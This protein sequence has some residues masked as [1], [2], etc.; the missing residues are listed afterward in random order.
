MDEIQTMGS[1]GGRMCFIKSQDIRNMRKNLIN[2]RNRNIL[3]DIRSWVRNVQ[4]IKNNDSCPIIYF[5]DRNVSD[6]KKILSNKDLMLIIM[7]KFQE[8]LLKDLG[9]K[10]LCLDATHCQENYEYQLLTIYTSDGNN[11]CPVVYCLTNIV[12]FTSVHY[13][14]K[15]VNEK[16]V[17][18]RCR[19][20]LSDDNLPFYDAW[21]DIISKPEHHFIHSW[22]IEKNWRE[23]ISKMKCTDNVKMMFYK[24][25]K[26]MMNE[27][28]EKTFEKMLNNFLSNFQYDTRFADFLSYFQKKYIKG[29]IQ[30]ANCYRKQSGVHLESSIELE[31]LHKRLYEEFHQSVNSQ[32]IKDCLN[33]LLVIS[34][35]C[36]VMSKKIMDIFHEEYDLR[37]R[38]IRDSHRRAVCIKRTEIS[39]ITP[40]L[41][42]V[43][44]DNLKNEIYQIHYLD[45]KK[46]S[47]L[48]KCNT[49]KICAHEYNCTCVDYAIN[50]NI[51]EHIH[52]CA[53]LRNKI[54]VDLS[55]ET[56]APLD[57]FVEEVICEEEIVCN[58]DNLYEDS[59]CEEISCDEID[60]DEKFITLKSENML[61]DD[62]NSDNEQW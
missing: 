62:V 41:Y 1:K 16:N 60:D 22:C 57:S 26:I 17:Q 18:L 39:E 32:K 11:W 33:F 9:S 5:K 52:A 40:T 38:C 48:F 12:N 35:N 23:N 46:C 54:N 34:N 31:Q 25:L 50:F 2:K 15:K 61:D 29:A 45:I 20:L 14:L 19:I 44:V 28:N 7:T 53:I 49:C 6:P 58:V 30:W 47:C 42:K 43:N 55:A 36:K 59:G 3:F 27:P 37:F 4:D 51:C 56:D 8:K 24:S 10:I 21:C 13:F